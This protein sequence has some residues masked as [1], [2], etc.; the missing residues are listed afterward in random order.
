MKIDFVKSFIAIAISALL[1]Y[2]CY[3]ICD[4]GQVKWVIT[5]GSF[6]TL[7]VPIMLVFGVS[8]KEERSSAMLKTLSCVFL[9]IEM[10]SNGV[11]VFIDF[12]IPVYVIFNG[13]ILLTFMLIYISI[14][15]TK[16]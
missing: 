3:E 2:A 6:V 11:Y 12:S 14:Y 4:Y 7:G 1:A 9:L 10:I 13:L 5:A 15:R 8:F 16:M